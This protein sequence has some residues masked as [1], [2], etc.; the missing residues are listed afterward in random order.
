VQIQDFYFQ[1]QKV[2][3]LVS[4][5]YLWNCTYE[6]QIEWFFYTEKTGFFVS[7]GSWFRKLITKDKL[8]ATEERTFS[9]LQ[10]IIWPISKDPYL[11]IWI[12]LFTELCPRNSCLYPETAISLLKALMVLVL[13]FIIFYFVCFHFIQ[14]LGEMNNPVK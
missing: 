10:K 13:V 6:N 3:W 12:I 2:A 8:I 11:L 5:D 1:D 7:L 4:F 14:K 9:V